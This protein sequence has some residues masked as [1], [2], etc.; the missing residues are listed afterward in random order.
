M[1]GVTESQRY[2]VPLPSVS[3]RDIGRI[4]CSWAYADR[5]PRS[6]VETLFNLATSAFG[7]RGQLET[8]TG[9]SVPLKHT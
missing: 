9:C 1:A 4:Y 7:I 6:R 2:V 5:P 8:P 3:N